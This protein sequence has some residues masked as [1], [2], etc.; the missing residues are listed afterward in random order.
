MKN[1]R[2][3]TADE[4]ARL[5]RQGCSAEDW[6]AVRVADGFG[7]EDIHNCRFAGRIELGARVT[8]RNIGCRIANYRIGDGVRIEHVGTLETIGTSTFGNGTEVRAVNENGGR[9]VAIFDTLSAQFAYM[10][11]MY[12]HRPLLVQRLTAMAESYTATVR[13]GMGTVGDGAQVANCGTL[14]N[15]RIG[16]FACLQDVTRLEN[17]TVNSTPEAPSHIGAG[18]RAYDFILMPGSV[19][20]NG[21]QLRNC[22]VGEAV[23]LSAFTADHALFFANAHCENGEAVSVFAGPYT[24]SHHKSS[25]LIAGMFSFFNAGSGANQ[26]NHLFKTG[27]VHQGIHQRGCKFASNAYVMLPA[28]NG[29][30]TV[31]LGRHTKHPD[32]ERFPFS[33]L[34]E[35]SGSSWLIPALGLRSYGTVRDL[36]KWP[37]RDNRQGIKRDRVNFDAFS[38]FIGERVRHAIETSLHLLSKEGIDIYNYERM[39]IRAAALRQGIRLY[40]M[41][42]DRILGALLA[43]GGTFR[44]EGAGHWV[45]LAGMFAPQTAVETL[46][47]RIEKG[48]VRTTEEVETSLGEINNAYPDYAYSW[49]YD[50]LAKLLGHTPQAADIANRVEKGKAAEE[51]YA[52][53][54]S[55]DAKNDSGTLMEIGYGIDTL[56]PEERE[57]DFRHVRGQ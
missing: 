47:D 13:S 11:A 15:V 8:I 16:A 32:T 41:E 26:S 40:E 57:A 55:D 21:T 31:V 19:T 36:E 39:K 12:R 4:I 20:D 3:L 44:K 43:R 33:Y 48:E 27:A 52:T 50:V 53:L 29:A 42:L 51:R 6:N 45:D 28:K 30:F 23:R 24:V 49:A 37:Q 38:P 7:T 25:L 9:S 18:V 5:E 46:L 14:R 35:E 1:Y 2:T 56:L 54:T 17:G 10:A 34:L 22:F